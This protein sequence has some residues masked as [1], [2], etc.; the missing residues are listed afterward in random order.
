MPIRIYWEPLSE[1]SPSRYEVYAVAGTDETW[2]GSFPHAVP[3]PNWADARRQFYYDDP[4]GTD[5]RIYRVR[6]LGDR[7]ELY[8]DT[9]PFQPST[10]LAAVLATRVRIDQ[11][12]PT[13]DNLRVTAPSGVG[14]P[15]ATIRVFRAPDWDA[16][17][18]DVALAVTQT[19]PNGEWKVPVWL[20]PGMDYVLVG[21]KLG[22][23]G[24]NIRRITV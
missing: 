17:R 21:E 6:A 4:L 3:G 14:I 15:D 24:P 9:G 19:G 2:L 10:A 7:G 23:F 11:D 22:A 20:E 5:A 13:F 1:L 12:W 18:K 8:G 16:N